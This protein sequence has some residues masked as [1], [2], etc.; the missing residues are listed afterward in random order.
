MG[1]MQSISGRLNVL[2]VVIVTLVLAGLGAFNYTS[3]KQRL[4]RGLEEQ[5]NALATRLQLSLPAAIWNFD[6]IQIAQI[7]EAEMAS[8]AF[9]G[10]LLSNGKDFID[11]RMRNAEG[12]LVPAPKDAKLAGSMREIKLQFDDNGQKKDVA[13]ATVYV[14]RAEVE[15]ALRENLITLAVQIIVL[16]VLLS[17]ALS[18]SL[19]AVVLKPLQRLNDALKEIASGDADLTRRLAAQGSRE[20]VEVSRSFNTFVARLQEV[21]KQIAETAPQLAAAAEQTSRITEQASEGIQQQQHETERIVSSTDELT[22]QV[23]EITSNTNAASEAAAYADAE[24][25]KGQAVV[26]DAIQT[27]GEA[28]AEVEN[29]AMVIQQLAESSDKIGTVLLVINEIAKQTNLLALNAAIEAARAG[30]AG[31]GF[32]VVADEVRTLANRTHD[33]TTEIQQVITQLQEGTMRAVT[34]ME[35]SKEKADLGLKRAREAGGAIHHLAESARK[36]AHLNEEIANASDRQDEMVSGVSSSIQQIQRIVGEAATGA[37][38]TAIAS[39]EVAKL[40]V[41]LQITVEQFK[42]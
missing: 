15:S 35:R 11:G 6:K 30:E 29:A 20:F 7:L 23:H 25:E 27:I 9:N 32:A 34:V 38:Q 5:A 1:F 16:D 8:V 41:R 42:V 21:M 40:A 24:A 37:Q 18:V 4:E 17:L 12:K 31:R 3:S 2:F 26:Q 28:T 10:I 22:S 19:S 33:Q 36:I 14:S 39:E 13:Q